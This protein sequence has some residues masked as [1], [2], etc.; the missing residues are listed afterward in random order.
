MGKPL[1]EGSIRRARAS[2][3]LIRA[4]AAT[5]RAHAEATK[6]QVAARAMF[7]DPVTDIVLRAASTPATLTGTGWADSLAATSIRDLVMEIS[8]VSA[9][10]A[11]IL[12]GLQLDFAGFASIKVPG[13]LV[14]ASDAGQWTVEGAPIVLRTQRVTAGCTLLPRKLSVNTS[15]TNE[16][17]RQSNIEAVSHALLT[18]ACALALDKAMLSATAANGQPA[19]ILAGLT[20]LTATAGGGLNALTSDVHNLMDALVT[21]YAGKAPVLIM[22]PTQALS[23]RMMASPL[24]NIPILESTV[25]ASTKTVILIEPSSFASAFDNV[26]E[27]NV[28]DAPLFHYEDTTALPINAGTMAV[29]VRSPFQTDSLVLQLKLRAAW[30]MR[31][32]ATAPHIA[33]VSG[34]SW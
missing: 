23:L 2:T 24:F 9:A 28:V 1:D 8:S 5:L 15:F 26:P 33:Y 7:G 27:F 32:A 18:E 4:A 19:G 20:A 17:V 12:R 6:P 21:N 30:G 13:R 3:Y 10:A 16:M 34:V 11:L 25:L 14:D 22:S 29:P 31:T